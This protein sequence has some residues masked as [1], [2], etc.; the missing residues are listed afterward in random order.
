MKTEATIEQRLE[1][2]KE[3]LHEIHHVA[4]ATVN[5]DGT[6]HSTP[7]FM[8]FDGRLNAFWASTTDSQH[9]KNI[10]RDGQVF[11]VVFDSREGHGGLYIRAEARVL[12]DKTGARHGH[13][14][15]QKLKQRLG[16]QLGGLELYLGDAP[17]RIYQATPLQ[18]WVNKS[19][20]SEQGVIIRDGR[21]EVT[22]DQ[23]LG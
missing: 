2:A 20:R 18:I 23:L 9:S 11:M 12:E 4:I 5:D 21:Y 6:P 15:L 13:A 17:Q 10:T 3:L 19:E 8:V 16:G 22:I 1:R 14:E 7:L